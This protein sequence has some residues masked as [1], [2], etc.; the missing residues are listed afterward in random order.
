MAQPDPELPGLTAA[1]DTPADAATTD[2]GDVGA[3]LTEIRLEENGEAVDEDSQGDA[4]GDSEEDTDGDSN[5]DI[6]SDAIS[7]CEEDPQDVYEE[8]DHPE[9]DKKVPAIPTKVNDIPGIIEKFGSSEEEF[10]NEV[11]LFESPMIICR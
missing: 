2:G 4:D 11:W 6:D 3:V 8:A 1:S 10:W 9:E 7:G 5:D